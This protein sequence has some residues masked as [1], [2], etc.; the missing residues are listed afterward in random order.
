LENVISLSDQLR[1]VESFIEADLYSSALSLV[2]GLLRSFKEF[3]ESGDKLFQIRLTLLDCAPGVWNEMYS[4]EFAVGDYG[5]DFVSEMSA[6][7]KAYIAALSLRLFLLR[8]KI[9][10]PILLRVWSASTLI[11]FGNSDIT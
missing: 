6:L 11:T 4:A 9:S 5:F 1:K 2:D 3:P 10:I 7:A 8:Q